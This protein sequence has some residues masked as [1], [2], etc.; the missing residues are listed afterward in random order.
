MTALDRAAIVGRA[1]DLVGVRFRAQGRE[2]STGLDCIGVV[3]EAMGIDGPPAHYSLRGGTPIEL[4]RGL[5]A[6][7]LRRTGREAEAGDVL[8]MRPAAEQLHLAIWTG[9]GIVHADA[10]LG[11][12]VERPGTPL[13]PVIDIWRMEQ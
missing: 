13:W 4:E 6:A 8:V 12:V 10:R 2:R 7:G 5:T 11:R 9:G 3:A 1:R